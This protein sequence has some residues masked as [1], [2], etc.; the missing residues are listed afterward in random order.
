MIKFFSLMKNKKEKESQPD[1]RIST[2][3]GEDYVDIGAAWI[4]EDKNGN[5]FLSCKL[6][7]IYKSKDKIKPG[8]HISEDEKDEALEKALDL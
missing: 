8:Y 6:S 5:K 2:K 1:Y 7:D 4:K 3:V